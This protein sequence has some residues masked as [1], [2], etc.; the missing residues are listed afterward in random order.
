MQDLGTLGGGYSWA[1]AINELGEIAG[2]SATSAGE[3]H[4]ALWR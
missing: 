1:N 4:A 2:Y 3:A